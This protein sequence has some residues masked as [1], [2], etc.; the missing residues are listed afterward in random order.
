V[1]KDEQSDDTISLTDQYDETEGASTSQTKADGEEMVSCKAPLKHI[2]HAGEH[3][4]DE[5][6]VS[7]SRFVDQLSEAFN[8][9]L[10]Q[11]P[12]PDKPPPITN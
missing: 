1:P 10:G 2:K 9:W 3:L 6:W 5:E 7:S 11:E 12:H 4:S 8:D